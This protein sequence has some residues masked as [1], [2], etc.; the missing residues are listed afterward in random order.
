V[1]KSP[2][3]RR[4]D[5]PELG[6]PVSLSSKRRGRQWNVPAGGVWHTVSVPAPR[7]PLRRNSAGAGGA[8]GVLHWIRW[9]SSSR[10][11]SSPDVFAIGPGTRCADQPGRNP[12]RLHPDWRRGS[13]RARGKL[14]RVGVLQRCQ[15]EAATRPSRRRSPRWSTKAQ[16][17]NSSPRHRRNLARAGRRHRLVC[18]PGETGAFAEGKHGKARPV[19]DLLLTP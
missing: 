9:W 8:D 6:L 11:T 14:A 4:A 3:W 5:Q 2:L 7:Y 13:S 18:V 1:R 15:N 16:R 19:R 17:R 12:R 10:R